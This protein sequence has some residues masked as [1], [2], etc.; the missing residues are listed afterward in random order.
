MGLLEAEACTKPDKAVVFALTKEKEKA[1]A[2]AAA[3]KDQVSLSHESLTTNTPTSQR[4]MTHCVHCKA[5][6]LFIRFYTKEH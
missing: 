2:E 1:S 6:A 5:N 4:T 3:L